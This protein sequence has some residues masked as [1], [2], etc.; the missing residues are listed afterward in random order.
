[1][2]YMGIPLLAKC[3]PLDVLPCTLIYLV[4]NPV[5]NTGAFELTYFENNKLSRIC[6]ILSVVL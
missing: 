4:V 3:Q 5:V 2:G 1:M 6:L